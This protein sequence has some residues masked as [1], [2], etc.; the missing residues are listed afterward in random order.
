MKMGRLRSIET[1]TKGDSNS[2]KQTK[3]NEDSSIG[4][5]KTAFGQWSVHSC[6]QTTRVQCKNG[7][8]EKNKELCTL[9]QRVLSLHK[10]N[11]KKN[12]F[13][14]LLKIIEIARFCFPSL[15]QPVEVAGQPAS[16]VR[17]SRRDHHGKVHAQCGVIPKKRRH[18]SAE[19]KVHEAGMSSR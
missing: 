15:D 7:K 16:L 11:K 4:Q 13:F 10:H 9:L 14:F 18:V 1:V 17:C 19:E 2:I 5:C 6:L 3:E 8:T 12:K